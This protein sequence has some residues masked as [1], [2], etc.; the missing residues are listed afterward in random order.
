MK[1]FRKLENNVQKKAVRK[2]LRA[3]GNLIRKDARNRAPVDT[4]ELLRSIKVRALSRSRNSFGVTVK[5]GEG[6]F[7]GD[8]FYSGFIEFGTHKIEAQP[9]LRPAFDANVDAVLNAVRR[10][11]RAAITKV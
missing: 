9:F 4:G 10:E 6:F 1:Q 2:A 3:G 5:T 7:K 8:Q 11:L